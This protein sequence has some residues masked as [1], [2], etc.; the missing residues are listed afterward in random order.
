MILVPSC[1]IV[2]DRGRRVVHVA[3]V[4][5]VAVVAVDA[6]WKQPSRSGT[7]C[8]S[9][10]IT[11]DSGL[12]WQLR[13]RSLAFARDDVSLGTKPGCG[14]LQDGLQLR[15]MSPE[16]YSIS[17]LSWQMKFDTVL[18]RQ[19]VRRVSTNWIPKRLPAA[20]TRSPIAPP[21]SSCCP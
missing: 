11:H 14:R 2:P 6:S 10:S 4:V 3:V 8:R 20:T 17:R 7:G 19:A 12:V 15:R 9:I 5:V 13:Q 18:P 16:L 21:P 1:V